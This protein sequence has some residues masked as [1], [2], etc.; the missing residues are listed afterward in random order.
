MNLGFNYKWTN[1]VSNSSEANPWSQTV[2]DIELAYMKE[3]KS[4]GVTHIRLHVPDF[5]SVGDVYRDKQLTLLAQ[6]AGFE[7]VTMGMSCNTFNNIAYKITNNVWQDYRDFC[8]VDNGVEGMGQA[9]YAKSIGVNTFFQ[10]NEEGLHHVFKASS[11]SS[12]HGKVVLTSSGTT[13]TATLTQTGAKWNFTDGQEVTIEGATQSEYNGTFEITLV[14]DTVFTYT[15]SGDPV[16]TAT[17]SYFVYDISPTEMV[18]LQ[19]T[20]A[21]DIKALWATMPGEDPMLATCIS[22][23]AY[24]TTDTELN[25]WIAAGKGDDLDLIGVNIYGEGDF[26]TFVGFAED[27]FNA[28]DTNAIV[29]EFNVHQNWTSTNI[30]GYTPSSNDQK[31]FHRQYEVALEKRRQ[32][33]EDAGFELAYFF[34]YFDSGDNAFA[35]KLNDGDAT[36]H[37]AAF[38]PGDYSP[39]FYRMLNVRPRTVTL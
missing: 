32:A 16:D 2:K 37:Q 25:Y 10:G 1:Y 29:T 34:N 13:A 31:E 20:L 9:A 21:A 19:K 33:L 4:Y 27:A 38:I 7:H 36:A 39:A 6:Q 12:S 23:D 11:A 30:N 17:G 24:G 5:F 18:A 22:A 8:L 15:M 3:L 35:V 26:N 28:F 14:S